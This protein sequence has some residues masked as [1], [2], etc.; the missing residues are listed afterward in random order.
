MVVAPT[1]ALTMRGFFYLKKRYKNYVSNVAYTILWEEQMSNWVTHKYA[2]EKLGVPSATLY[3]WGKSKQIPRKYDKKRKLYMVDI[4]GFSVSTYDDLNP[5]F[6]GN[7]WLRVRE[8][9]DKFG[10]TDS[11]VRTWI[12]RKMIKSKRV[13]RGRKNCVYVDISSAPKP[14]RIV[15][16]PTTTPNTPNTPFSRKENTMAIA[17]IPRKQVEA[18]Y[19]DIHQQWIN[20]IM[21]SDRANIAKDTIQRLMEKL[22]EEK[23]LT[24]VIS[25]I[26]EESLTAEKEELRCKAMGETLRESKKRLEVLLKVD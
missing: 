14:A 16:K 7:K 12:N 1:P 3:R 20:A 18:L 5:P 17:T 8:A 13:L 2:V 23:D 22:G 26:K 24:S 10:I 9:A 6:T 19:D 15:L 4:E 21:D 11:A 25:L